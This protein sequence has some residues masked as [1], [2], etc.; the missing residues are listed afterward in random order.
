MSYRNRAFGAKLTLAS[1]PNLMA[2]TSRVSTTGAFV[3]F[4]SGAFSYL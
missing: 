3:N 1:D 4:D 2:R